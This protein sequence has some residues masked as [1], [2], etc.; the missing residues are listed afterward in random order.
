MKL[1]RCVRCN[2]LYPEW[3]IHYSPAVKISDMKRL[4]DG[5]HCDKCRKAII[6]ERAPYAKKNDLCA[7]CDEQQLKSCIR[8]HRQYCIE[9]FSSASICDFC[10]KAKKRKDSGD[11]WGI[12]T[13]PEALTN[14][15]WSYGRSSAVPKGIYL[16]LLEDGSIRSYRYNEKG[17]IEEISQPSVNRWEVKGNQLIFRNAAGRITTSFE[18]FNYVDE[19]KYFPGDNTPKKKMW[20]ITGPCRLGDYDSVIFQVFG[21]WEKFAPPKGTI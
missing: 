14:I 12:P 17:K 7:V 13:D 19:L 6:D 10:A 1:I 3:E 11:N 8:C 18:K 9:H 16:H 4:P 2:N 15:I 5:Y 20:A 21:S